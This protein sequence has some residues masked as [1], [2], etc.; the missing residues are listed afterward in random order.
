MTPEWRPDWGGILQFIDARG[1]I[2]EG[3]TPCFN[4]LNIFRVPAVHSVSQV[5]LYGGFRYSVTG[6]FHAR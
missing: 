1:N 3:Y 5:A 2:A 6:W 4:A